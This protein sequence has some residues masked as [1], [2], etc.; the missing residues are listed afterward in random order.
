MGK[1]TKK[2][3]IFK[4][5]INEESFAIG[6]VLTNTSGVLR[7]GVFDMVATSADKLDLNEIV[8]QKFKFLTDTMD[9]LIWHGDWE[10]MG[11]TKHKFDNLPEP[12]FK[13][14]Q[15]EILVTNYDQTQTRRAKPDEINFLDYKFSV[16]PIRVENAVKAYNGLLPWDKEFDKLTYEYCDEKSKVRL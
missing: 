4:I 2:G 13:I 7:V 10:I 3:D 16:A 6:V 8:N 5:P 12:K 15:D 11:A 1:R 9:A 14:G